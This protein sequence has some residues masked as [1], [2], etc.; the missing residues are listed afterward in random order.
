MRLADPYI[1]FTEND[2]FPVTPTNKQPGKQIQGQTFGIQTPQGQGKQN[3][4]LYMH[5]NCFCAIGPPKAD[6]LTLRGMQ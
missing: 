5:N 6:F 1:R 3:R 2:Q 4:T